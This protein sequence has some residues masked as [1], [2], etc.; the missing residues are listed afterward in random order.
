MI[1]FQT[2]RYT[3]K[4]NKFKR[5]KTFVE[6]PEKYLKIEEYVKIYD[7][8]LFEGNYYSKCPGVLLKIGFFTCE[9]KV[10][11]MKFF[12]LDIHEGAEFT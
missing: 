8:R 12:L 3:E 11:L 4:K 2:N 9:I 7:K 10:Y 1:V 5:K 6:L